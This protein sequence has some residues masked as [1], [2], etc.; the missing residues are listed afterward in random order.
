M[1]GVKRR[2]GID[3]FDGNNYKPNQNLIIMRT[4][5]FL[6][7]LPLFFL[8]S[9]SEN[10]EPK[11]EAAPK[12][13][14]KTEKVATTDNPCTKTAY[15][16]Y[17][18]TV[19]MWENSWKWDNDIPASDPTM[20]YA[21]SKEKLNELRDKVSNSDGLRMYYCLVDG[22]TIPSIAI[23]NLNGC[24]DNLGDGESVLLSDEEGGH[25]VNTEAAAELTA[26]WR[27]S[28]FYLNPFY[29]PINGY[30]YNWEIVTNLLGYSGNSEQKL[31]VS[32]GLRT[33]SP[34]DPDFETSG[35]NNGA[36]AMV[37]ILHGASL[38][39]VANHSFDFTMP[40]P[41][42]CDEAGSIL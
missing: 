32:F 20:S 18:K 38:L 33:I 21:F 16:V 14:V 28:A 12:A 9:C 30:N 10:S 3:T 19:E 13:E 1:K 23:V 24:N 8:I 29:V 17:R 39:S 36:I 41:Q 2:L 25:F 37:N 5:H 7:A 40:C 4:I 15:Q 26:S 42:M 34:N 22:N 11:A 6:Y 35:L 27:N 31:Y